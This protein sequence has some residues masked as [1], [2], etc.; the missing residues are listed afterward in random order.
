MTILRIGS[1]T[2]F[3]ANFQI[4]I[5]RQKVLVNK[6]RIFLKFS[7]SFDDNESYEKEKLDI[8]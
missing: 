1:E 6:G 3:S 4:K 8:L 7:W 2:F 5:P